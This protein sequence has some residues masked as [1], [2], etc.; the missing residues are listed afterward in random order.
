MYSKGS[1]PEQE[2]EQDTEMDIDEGGIFEEHSVFELKSQLDQ[3]RPFPNFSAGL[4]KMLTMMQPRMPERLKRILLM[5]LHEP[6][7]VP[8]DCPKT[9]S[10]L[11]S[12]S[13][14]LPVAE[15]E[16]FTATATHAYKTPR[17]LADGTTLRYYQEQVPLMYYTPRVAIERS[18]ND[19][20]IHTII[21]DNQTEV[22]PGTYRCFLDSDFIK[23]PRKYRELMSFHAGGVEYL[24]GDCFRGDWKLYRIEKLSY[25]QVG[26]ETLKEIKETKNYQRAQPP[27]IIHVSE[28]ELHDRRYRHNPVVHEHKPDIIRHKVHASKKI[29]SYISV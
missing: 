5:I 16:K 26:L 4:I 27:L 13:D 2:L 24:V 6:D 9:L 21:Q 11:D 28:F 14:L 23:R 22:P 1:Q 12:L 15:G 17:K 29:W 18:L 25:R 19:P 10:E 8:T 7:F 20:R 3:F